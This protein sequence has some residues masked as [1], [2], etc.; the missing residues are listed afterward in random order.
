[1]NT[2][3][4]KIKALNSHFA[5]HVLPLMQRSGLTSLSLLKDVDAAACQDLMILLYEAAKV[6]KYVRYI[7]C[8]RCESSTDSA[9]M[10][11][12]I[13]FMDDVQITGEEIRCSAYTILSRKAC[14]L[15]RAVC[16]K[17]EGVISIDDEKIEAVVHQ[18]S[19]L[20]PADAY[21][22]YVSDLRFEAVQG[23][24]RDVLSNS[25]MNPRKK[26]CW[27]SSAAEL[28]PRE[29]EAL[30]ECK[31]LVRASVDVLN[32]VNKI[33]GVFKDKQVLHGA[34][35]LLRDLEK[36]AYPE[37]SNKVI[38]CDKSDVNKM[39]RRKFEK[40]LIL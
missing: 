1:M 13:A 25:E 31:G 18:H 32:M 34:R 23:L 15:L 28:N 29:F 6:S 10:D 40:S 11:A 12:V 20:R 7:A 30:I 35:A 39:L 21:E 24:L 22:S 2:S 14:D 3:Y 17:K 26:I 38:G 16:R 9:A 8:A 36:K 37:L 5:S 27:L 33:Y 4:E 19:V